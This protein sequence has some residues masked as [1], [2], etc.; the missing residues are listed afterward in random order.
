M[1]EETVKSRVDLVILALAVL[2]A[3]SDSS[4]DEFGVLGLLRRSKDERRVGGSVLRLILGNGREVTRV[5][6]DGL[7]NFSSLRRR[8]SLSA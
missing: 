8:L 3:V 7:C 2:A 6:N 5:A 1:N 4:V